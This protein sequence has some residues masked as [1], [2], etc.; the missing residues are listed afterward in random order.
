M[1]V[2]VVVEIDDF[3]MYIIYYIINNV[4]M[5]L[6]DFEVF[7]GFGYWKGWRRI[8]C[9]LDIDL[10]KGVFFVEKRNSKRGK[11]LLIEV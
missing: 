3:V 1:C 2:L 5:V 6:M 7:Y 4:F 11:L 9:D 8:V 10:R